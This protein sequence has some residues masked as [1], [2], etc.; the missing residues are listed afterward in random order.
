MHLPADE[1]FQKFT[2]ITREIFSELNEDNSEEE[3]EFI[4]KKQV[5]LM[6]DMSE[7]SVENYTEQG[8]Y[9][10]Y[11]A[12]RTIRYKKSEVIAA[13]KKVTHTL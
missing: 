4:S 11:R 7:K 13:W 10:A 1:A 8:I 6:T 2:D 3:T 5:A 9:I 12:G